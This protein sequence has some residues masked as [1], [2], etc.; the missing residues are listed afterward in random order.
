MGP[1]GTGKAETCLDL[2]RDCGYASLLIPV[3]NTFD[4]DSIEKK[5]LPGLKSLSTIG[6]VFDCAHRSATEDAIGAIAKMTADAVTCPFGVVVTSGDDE[7]SKFIPEKIGDAATIS[8]LTVPPYDLI[9]E[10][11]LASE[12]FLQYEMLASLLVQFMEYCKDACSKQAYHDFGLR[13]GKHTVKAAASCH[14]NREVAA[15]RSA[16]LLNV[17]AGMAAD[18]QAL[19]TAKLMELFVAEEALGEASRAIRVLE[20]GQYRHGILCIAEDPEACKA[21]L[22]ENFGSDRNPMKECAAT[23]E[24]IGEAIDGIVHQK[25]LVNGKMED[26]EALN[27]LLDDNK[28]LKLADKEVKLGDLV[29]IIFILTPDDV[30]N[31]SPASVSRCGRVYFP[32]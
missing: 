4:V 20:L 28:V 11:M 12:G 16:L 15:L 27:T 13:A 2:L 5:I 31:L 10:V 17:V 8:T 30:K 7:K 23:P 26:M 3:D 14:V 6:V 24:A 19:A 21:Q 9:Y 29:N 32:A 25:V 1:P 18:D 22:Q